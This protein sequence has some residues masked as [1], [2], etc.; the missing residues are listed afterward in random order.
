MVFHTKLKWL[1]FQLHIYPGLSQTKPDSQA[2][3]RCF[4]TPSVSRIFWLG[5]PYNMTW[6]NNSACLIVVSTNTFSLSTLWRLRIQAAQ[7]PSVWR[8]GPC[9]SHAVYILPTYY[10]Y[11]YYYYYL[12]CVLRSKLCSV[13]RHVPLCVVALSHITSVVLCWLTRDLIRQ[14]SPKLNIFFHFPQHKEG[15]NLHFNESNPKRSH[16][17][18]F[19]RCSKIQSNL[20]H[21]PSH[22]STK[23]QRIL[24]LHRWIPTLKQDKKLANR[25]LSARLVPLARIYEDPFPGWTWW[26]LFRAPWGWTRAAPR[27]MFEK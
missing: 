27:L 13:N 25:I 5:M 2:S 4:M 17:Y 19:L 16:P 8:F 18:L 24:I 14:N 10:I 20:F 21:F 22:P 26:Q 15:F 7:P 3:V 9:Q 23:D 6:G 1:R 11:Y 12:F